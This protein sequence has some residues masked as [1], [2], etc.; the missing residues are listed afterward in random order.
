[1]YELVRD[2]HD[3]LDGTLRAL[4]QRG[5]SDDALRALLGVLRHALAVHVEA[6]AAVLR[7]LVANVR[8][9]RVVH[10]L[11]AQTRA[12]HIDQLIAVDDLA[13]VQ[14]GSSEWY[15]LIGALRGHIRDHSRHAELASST[16]RYHVPFGIQSLLTARYAHA[17]E[18]AR[19]ARMHPTDSSN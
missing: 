3:S 14:P 2:D 17:R 5:A 19:A 10:M 6:E 9:P 13:R 18:Q 7:L 1:M 4:L 11:A 8:G 12:E 15:E 16:F